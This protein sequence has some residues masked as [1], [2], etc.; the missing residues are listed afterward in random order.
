MRA[1]LVRD[2]HH[3]L[4]EGIGLAVQRLQR[5]ARFRE[6]RADVARELGV[7]EGMQRPAEVDRQIL[8]DIDQ[9]GY[10]TEANRREAIFK[11]LRA[12]AVL[13]AANHAA[14]ELRAFFLALIRRKPHRHVAR[15]FEAARHGRVVERLK[16]AHAGGR[17][18]RARRRARPAHRRGSVSD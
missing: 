3:A 8:R 17:H 13:D 9:R 18:I 14:H 16:L 11:P 10:R 5:L 15:T 7:V 1:G 6:A 2:H 4:V 12:L